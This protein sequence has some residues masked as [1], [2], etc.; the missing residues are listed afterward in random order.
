MRGVWVCR[1][2]CKELEMGFA[3]RKGIGLNMALRRYPLFLA[4]WHLKLVLMAENWR[5]YPLCCL[6]KYRH[7]GAPAR[8]SQKMTGKF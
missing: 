2:L 3:R 1:V 5:L 8:G 6:R 7:R 4:F